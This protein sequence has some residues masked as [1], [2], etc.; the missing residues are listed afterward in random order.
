M[1]GA[2]GTTQDRAAKLKQ[3]P[4][5]ADRTRHR[6]QIRRMPLPAVHIVQTYAAHVVRP[7]SS[8]SRGPLLILTTKSFID[9][10]FG[11]DV[12]LDNL[13]LTNSRVAFTGADAPTFFIL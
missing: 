4:S 13:T 3:F 11:F 10:D 2:L 8:L 5:L 9:V 12:A 6:Y 1:I 7:R